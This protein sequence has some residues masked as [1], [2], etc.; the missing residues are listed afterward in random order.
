MVVYNVLKLSVYCANL[1]SALSDL[2]GYFLVSSFGL[3]VFTWCKLVHF[4]G[5]KKI[6]RVCSDK[7]VV[8][9]FLVINWIIV[10]P[11]CLAEAITTISIIPFLTGVIF[12]VEILAL[13]IIFIVYGITLLIRLGNEALAKSSKS[14]K[15]VTLALI[16]LGFLSL[17]M[18]VWQALNQFLSHPNPNAWS[19]A[20]VLVLFI[21]ENIIYLLFVLIFGLNEIKTLFTAAL[22]KIGLFEAK[23]QSEVSVENANKSPQLSGTSETKSSGSSP[24]IPMTVTV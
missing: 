10:L 15:K 19:D 8:I 22:A 14:L 24:D 21:Y 17:F 12:I 16:L 23:V 4:T 13:A 18:V 2:G 7:K 6:D 5:S 20:N 9:Y 11:F 1:C 3:I